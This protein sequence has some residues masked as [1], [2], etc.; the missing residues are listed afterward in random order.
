MN[1]NWMACLKCPSGRSVSSCLPTAQAPTAT[2]RAPPATP[3]PVISC[4][5][6]SPPCASTRGGVGPGGGSNGHAY[7]VRSDIVLLAR[8]LEKA[9]GWLQ[10]DASTRRL[11][12]GLYG[13][14]TSAAVVMQLAA[15]RS[16]EIAALAVCDGQVEMAGKAALENVRVPSLLIVGGRD[17]DVAGLNRMA[18]ATL[19]CD[20]Q[21][22]QIAAPGGPDTRHQAAL[23]ATDW[24][25]RHFNGHTSTSQ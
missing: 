20:K 21:L 18:F 15:W 12:C 5:R 14:G 22:E 24:Y 3:L 2:T 25:T 6:V 10:M 8:Q 4:E 9:T 19:R 17:P 7:F 11:P 1:F 16:A 13:Y 23:L